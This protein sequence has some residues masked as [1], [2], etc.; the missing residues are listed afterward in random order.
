MPIARYVEVDFPHLTA[1][2]AQ[3]IARNRALTAAL[4]PPSPEPGAMAAPPRTY[5]VSHGGAALTAPNYALLPLDLRN[6]ASLDEQLLPLLDTSLPTLL[7]AECVF[8][9]MKEEDSRAVI[10]WFGSTFPR[11]AAVIYEMVGLK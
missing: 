1:M 9:Y 2:K 7:L 6:A 8:C 3:R 4:E 11:S 10:Q 5:R